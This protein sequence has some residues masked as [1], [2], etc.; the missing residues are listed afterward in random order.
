[1]AGGE[2]HPPKPKTSLYSEEECQNAMQ[3]V[4]SK[5]F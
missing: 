5:K 2:T 4:Q 3:W 1:M